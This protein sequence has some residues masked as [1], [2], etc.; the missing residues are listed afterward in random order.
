MDQ[1]NYL[2]LK[3]I[4][5]NELMG[6]HWLFLFVGLIFIWYLSTKANLPNQVPLILSIF[7]VGIVFTAVYD[8]IFIAWVLA[9]LAVGFLFYYNVSKIINRG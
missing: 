3:D 2:D 4:W 5:I 9:V 8:A 6:S 7:W 1:T